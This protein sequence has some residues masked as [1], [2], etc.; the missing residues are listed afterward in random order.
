MGGYVGQELG[1]LALVRSRL[2]KTIEMVPGTGNANDP[3]PEETL[4]KIELP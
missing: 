2:L 4:M 3:Q 1:L